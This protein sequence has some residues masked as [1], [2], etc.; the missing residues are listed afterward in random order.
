M[1][2][3]GGSFDNISEVSISDD[4]RF[5][6]TELVDECLKHRPESEVETTYFQNI[7]EPLFRQIASD[8][9]FHRPIEVVDFLL[10][11]V[12]K[13]AGKPLEEAGLP[14]CSPLSQIKSW[15][16]RQ[17]RFKNKHQSTWKQYE[18]LKLGLGRTDAGKKILEA[19]S[20]EDQVALDAALA[21]SGLADTNTV[22]VQPFGGSGHGLIPLDSNPSTPSTPNIYRLSPSAA[23]A[24]AAETMGEV[25]RALRSRGVMSASA[26]F[27]HFGKGQDGCISM[28]LLL[29]EIGSFGTVSPRRAE[30]LVRSLDR[31]GTSRIEYRDFRSKI[32]GFLATSREFHS[33]LGGDELNAIMV[34]IQS[35]LDQRGLTAVEAF[36][37]W[38]RSS[39]GQLDCNEFIT[40]LRSLRLGLSSKEVAQVFKAVS[41]TSNN[42]SDLLPKNGDKNVVDA[43][44]MTSLQNFELMFRSAKQ[45]PSLRDWA[46]NSFSLLR[47]GLEL[48]AV[49]KSL[50]YF[51]EHSDLIHYN[52]F[53]AL[54][55]D[56][57]PKCTS[58]EIGKLWCVLDKEDGIEEPVVTIQ[59]LLRWMAPRGRVG[60]QYQQQSKTIVP[61]ISPQ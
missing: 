50:R 6:L 33:S 11:W 51:S 24:E 21:A 10:D 17:L 13:R 18:M 32:S 25:L 16:D 58:I 57:D 29:N 7:L 37:E 3:E 34:R 52:G 14:S 60:K 36:R 28:D 53:A 15:C 43:G 5:C 8:A 61:F 56:I 12:Q 35:K 46:L 1:T 49:E 20:Q 47:E 42:V 27:E 4:L 54:V 41:G 48:C 2:S 45:Q 30:R 31:R 23:E 40:G 59:E 22:A 38:D 19:A 9:I 39:C 55:L 44:C 26:A